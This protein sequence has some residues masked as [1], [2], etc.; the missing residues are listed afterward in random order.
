MVC[1][2]LIIRG[3][4]V[5][6]VHQRIAHL[7]LSAIGVCTDNG[8]DGLVTHGMDMHR[9]SIGIRLARDVCQFLFG[10]VGEALMS[11][12]IE[13]IHK[14]RTAFH[15]T[16][17]EEFEPVRLDVGGGVLLNVKGFFQIFIH[18]HPAFNLVG[19]AQH[20]VHLAGLIHLLGSLEEIVVEEIVAPTVDIH[21]VT[22]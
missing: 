2:T 12:G 9:D 21:G 6:H 18:I 8:I 5:A 7:V 10:P 17:H 22:L 11:V 20:E 19:Q 15:R 14:A 13:R 4:D 1:H 16:V 3:I